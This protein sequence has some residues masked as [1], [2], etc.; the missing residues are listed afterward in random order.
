[1]ADEISESAM[2]NRTT[3]EEKG[4]R[5]QQDAWTEKSP[6]GIVSFSYYNG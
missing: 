1:V 4:S 2:N 6:L 3:S 5:E